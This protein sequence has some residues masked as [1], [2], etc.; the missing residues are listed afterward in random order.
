MRNIAKLAELNQTAAVF[1]ERYGDGGYEMA[2]AFAA[3]FAAGVKAGKRE[4]M[5]EG[6]RERKETEGDS[7]GV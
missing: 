5:A 2:C 4:S 1:A 6:A 3:A 7:D